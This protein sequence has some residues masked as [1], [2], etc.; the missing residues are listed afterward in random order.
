MNSIYMIITS[1]A[2][3]ALGKGSFECNFSEP[4]ASPQCFGAVGQPLIFHLPDTVDKDIKLTKDNKS[5]ILKAAKNQIQSLDE[6]Y[7]YKDY[8]FTS[9]TLNLRNAMKRHSG[10]Y[11]LE[12]HGP[13]GALLKKVQVHLEI[14]APVSKPAVSQMCLSPEVMKVSC[15][16]EGDGVEFIL[17]LD[18]NL[19][20]PTGARSTDEQH[21][22]SV[23]NVTI[24]L[25]GQLIGNLTCTVQ[26]NVSREETVIHLTSCKGSTSH[27][28]LVTV[29][30]IASAATLLL[31]LLL[32]LLL[33]FGIKF[34]NKKA[35]PMKVNK[36]NAEDEIVYSEVKVRKLT[37]ETRPKPHQNTT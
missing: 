2:A 36:D 14:Q 28:S 26:N 22:P 32:I 10:N 13:D 19:L 25:H 11:V 17:T 16:S 7:V 5:R 24:S 37:R 1:L 33:F 4:N 30:A 20:I 15:S 6:E 3:A 12:Q 18:S 31:L 8:N 29:A 9:G 23:S 27:L 21:Q 34:L 35:R